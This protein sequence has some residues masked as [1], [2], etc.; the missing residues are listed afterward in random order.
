MPKLIR[1]YPTIKLIITGGGF[2]KNF[3]WLDYKGVISKNSLYNLYS[4]S[5]CMC[6]PLKFDQEQELKL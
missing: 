4:N 5:I 2:N 6:V 1:K 3:S